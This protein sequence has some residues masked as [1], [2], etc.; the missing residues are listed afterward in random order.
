MLLTHMFSQSVLRLAL[1]CSLNRYTF[2]TRIDCCYY[3]EKSLKEHQMIPDLFYVLC[4]IRR[5]SYS[6]VPLMLHKHQIFSSHRWGWTFGISFCCPI[7]NHLFK[8]WPNTALFLTEWMSEI[9]KPISKSSSGKIP[10]S[11]SREFLHS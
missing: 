9:S 10:L 2:V 1:V 4:F 11:V 3:F 7:F 6:M 8:K 5:I